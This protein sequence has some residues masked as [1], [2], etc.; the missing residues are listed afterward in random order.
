MRRPGRIFLIPALLALASCIGRGAPATSTPEAEFR[1]SNTARPFTFTPPPSPV[2]AEKGPSP[3]TSALPWSIVQALEALPPSRLY[4]ETKDK[5]LSIRIDC[6]GPM[7][8]CFSEPNSISP[9]SGD[10]GGMEVSPDGNLVAIERVDPYGASGLQRSIRLMSAD[11]K[12]IWAVAQMG[13]RAPEWSPDGESIAYIDYLVSGGQFSRICF[14]SIVQPYRCLPHSGSPYGLGSLAWS[15][16]GKYLA[17]CEFPDPLFPYVCDLSVVDHG[18]SSH[19]LIS[20][21][22]RDPHWSPDGDLLLFTYIPSEQSIFMAA[23]VN[24]CVGQEDNCASELEPIAPGFLYDFSPDGTHATYMTE[25][26]LGVVEAACVLDPQTC[27]EPPVLLSGPENRVLDYSWSPEGDHIAYAA[28]DESE[29]GIF[30]VDIRGYGTVLVQ[31]IDP[32]YFPRVDWRP[33]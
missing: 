27:T 1:L 24:A 10:R 12:R 7:G 21:D 25:G 4:F 19:T 9:E 32:D 29:A 20:H 16:D 18:T 17:Y 14:S 11:G 2:H 8:S 6:S 28:S 5:V 15:P 3:T 22:A 31:R 30:I 13:T 26:R 33:P 23:N